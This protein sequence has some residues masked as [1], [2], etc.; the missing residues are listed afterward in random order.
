MLGETKLKAVLLLFWMVTFALPTTS[1]AIPPPVKDLN[2]IWDGGAFREYVWDLSED[3][4]GNYYISALTNENLLI[5]IDGNGN[6]LWRKTSRNTYSEATGQRGWI[7]LDSSGNV[8][9][10][11]QSGGD[12]GK[13]YKFSPDGTLLFTIPGSSRGFSICN[14]GTQELAKLRIDN[15]GNLLLLNRSVN[16]FDGQTGALIW[17]GA[18]YPHDNNCSFDFTFDSA[19]NVYITGMGKIYVAPSGYPAM[20]AKLDATTGQRVWYQ[21][22]NHP[23]DSLHQPGRHINLDSAGNLLVH[24][25]FSHGFDYLLSYDVAGNLL[26]STPPGSL[27]TPRPQ[28][29][30]YDQATDSIYITPVQRRGL[31]AVKYQWS[32]AGVT[33]V[34]KNSYEESDSF[35]NLL[36]SIG[37]DIDVDA[38]GN[39]LVAGN[40]ETGF[41]W[42][43]GKFCTVKFNSDGS[44]NW[45]MRDERAGIALIAR[46]TGTGEVMMGGGSYWPFD[47]TVQ[48]YRDGIP[49]IPDTDGDGLTDDID[50]CPL[51]PN[52]DQLDIPDAD[53]QGNACDNDDDNDGQTD[54]LDNCPDIA[55]VDQLDNDGDGIGNVCD[56]DNDNDSVPDDVDNC[57]LMPNTDQADSDL[58]MIGDMC[59]IDDDN[60]SYLDEFDN[61]PLI[62]NSDQLDLDLDGQGDACDGDDDGDGIGDGVDVC[63]GSPLGSSIDAEGCTGPQRIVHTCGD[64]AQADFANHGQYVKCVTQM[65]NEVARHG[66][67]TNNEKGRLIR[68]AAIKK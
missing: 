45:V 11:I 22:F 9:W 46:N 4:L 41:H 13:V 33:Q 61:C 20:T 44:L 31:G 64:G 17:Q 7:H 57:P 19:N 56:N 60:D 34:W 26:S 3:G 50:N 68:A 30:I 36:G 18:S 1:L 27:E 35:G 32:N 15:E 16:K 6:E 52:P 23:Q 39:V 55:N 29:Y 63:P 28:G 21:K 42:S 43:S 8:Y 47:A 2:V 67:I 38:N 40:C 37:V 5:K 54:Q 59:D 66:L 10:V 24:V 51:L 53:G 49:P 12:F 58:D 48:R 62:A 65:A 14:N 25:T